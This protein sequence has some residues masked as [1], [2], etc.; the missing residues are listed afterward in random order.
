LRKVVEEANASLAAS[1]D[2]CINTFEARVMQRADKRATR[3]SQLAEY[4]SATIHLE[5]RLLKQS[6]KLRP[7]ILTK[8][9]TPICQVVKRRPSSSRFPVRPHSQISSVRLPT[10]QSPRLPP[11]CRAR[12]R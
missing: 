2:A 9:S 1:L 3:A 11:V 12:L 5:Q 8:D 4:T 6:N 7:L 10:S